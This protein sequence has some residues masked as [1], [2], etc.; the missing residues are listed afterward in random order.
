[1][2]TIQ[3][4]HI[5]PKADKKVKGQVGAPMPGSV[6]DIRV[7]V[8]DRV[9]KGAALIVLSAMKME[10]VVQAPIAGII[11]SLDVKPNMKLEGDDLLMTI[12]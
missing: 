2:C 5:H 7:A 8:G 6:I 11:K 1:M 12:E 9:E 4:L 3:E 10:M